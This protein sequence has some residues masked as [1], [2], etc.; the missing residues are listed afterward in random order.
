MT[1]LF[2]EGMDGFNV[3]L[4]LS[5]LWFNPKCIRYCRPQIR[6][7]TFS[8]YYDCNARTSYLA[9]PFT[10]TVFNKRVRGIAQYV[11]LEYECF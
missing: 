3:G 11:P 1:S 5:S 4:T 2:F 8:H 6:Y 7:K 9:V 10:L